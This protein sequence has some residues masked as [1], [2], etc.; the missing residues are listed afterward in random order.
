MKWRAASNGSTLQ[1]Y[2]EPCSFLN[3]RSG[4][5]ASRERIVQFKRFYH[6]NVVKDFH[7]VSCVCP[8]RRRLFIA[9]RAL[10]DTFQVSRFGL[11]VRVEFEAVNATQPYKAA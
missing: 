1:R 5:I 3:E 6:S 9:L 4:S 11:I 10:L 2:C 7:H 8:V